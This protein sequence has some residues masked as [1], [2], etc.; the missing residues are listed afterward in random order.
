MRG[1]RSGTGGNGFAVRSGLVGV[2]AVLVVVHGV[3]TVPG[4][5][6]QPGFSPL[7]DGWVQGT[8]YALCGMVALLGPWGARRDRGGWLALALAIAL[9]GLAFVVSLAWVQRQDVVPYP[10]V[11]D[12]LWIASGL[13]L[14]V[15][16]VL[17]VRVAMPR[18]STI[19]VLDAIA[20]ALLAG[21][22]AVAMV[23]DVLVDLAPAAAPSRVVATNLAYPISDVALLVL[24]VGLFSAFDWHP[25]R[26]D[27]VVAGGVAA[28]ATV[29]VV[30]LYQVSA[31][32]F[33]PG[34]PLASL[35]LVATALMALAVYVP[36]RDHRPRVRDGREPVGFTAAASTAAVAVAFLLY[37]GVVE[38]PFPSV[39]LASGSLLVLILRAVLTLVA[40]RAQADDLLRAKNAELLRFQALV[41]ASSDFIAIATMD[42]VVT[43]VNPAGRDLVGLPPERDV[44]TTTIADYLTEEGQRASIEVEQPAV[45]AHGRWEG[46]STLRDIRGGP[47]IP[48]AISSFLLFHPR[49]GEPVGLATVQRDISERMTAQRALEDL[50]RQRQVLLS[51]LVQAQE[52]ER[53]AIAADVH[54]DSVQALAAVDL[55]LG[56]LRRK[57]VEA[58]SDQ[59]GNVD[60]VLET[61]TAATARLRHLL[62]DLES[63]AQQQSL[64]GALEAAAEHVFEDSGITWALTGDRDVDLPGPARVTAYRI[65]KEAMVNARKHSGA[66]RVELDLARGDDGVLVTVADDGVGAEAD[67]IRRRHGHRGLASARDRAIIAG[68]WLQVEGTPDEGTRVILWLPD[69]AP[70]GLD[71]PAE[72]DDTGAS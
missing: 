34:T 8:A 10:S 63:P 5:R 50:A 69:V 35:S 11:A 12:A 55:R 3:S 28:F 38:L 29:D 56:L 20:A 16:L 39:A 72:A 67:G 61:V 1:P 32:T 24:V 40:D 7:M 27:V 46:E 41:D 45:V 14:M 68:G 62:F 22:V 19:L 42:G 58:G 37:D 54:D 17:R 26:A 25:P 51:R 66:H 9:R 4:V 31:G 43:Y 64:A 57:L 18:F 6:D 15:A 44:T 33:V 52:D 60:K 65:A 23:H 53:A 2:L 48:V 36:S 47:P 13:L 70:A 49:S 59:V 30:Y 71:D 21:A